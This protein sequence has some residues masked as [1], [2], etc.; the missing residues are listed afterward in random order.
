[1]AVEEELP[2]D[3]SKNLAIGCPMEV[4]DSRNMIELRTPAT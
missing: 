2:I 4:G 3:V 1:M